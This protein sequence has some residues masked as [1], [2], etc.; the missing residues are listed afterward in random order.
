MPLRL[1][2]S[3]VVAVIAI[4]SALAL[5]PAAGGET[6]NIKVPV[7]EDFVVG[8]VCNGEEVQLQGTLH[9]VQQ[10]GVVADAP[11]QHE[12]AQLNSQR[13]SGVGLT[14]GDRYSVNWNTQ[15]V[16]NA[17]IDGANV[18]TL[19]AIINVVSRGSGVNFQIQTVLHITFNANGEPTSEF[20]NF[21]VHCTG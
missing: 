5:A 12:V 3:A 10:G 7:G 17:R 6:I 2:R 21:H 18:T 19:G 20:Q 14:S 8:N 13:L 11:R 4:G 15:S 16:F 9:L 1:N